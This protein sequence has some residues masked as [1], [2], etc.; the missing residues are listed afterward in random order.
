MSVRNED[1]LDKRVSDFPTGVAAT[2]G[3]KKS[4]VSGVGDDCNSNGLVNSTRA[5]KDEWDIRISPFARLT[6]NPIRCIV[7]GLKLEPNP[8]KSFIPL[9]LGMSELFLYSLLCSK[10]EAV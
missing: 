5:K 2:A 9:S 6:I 10:F 8:D 7:E 1:H 3:L 4:L